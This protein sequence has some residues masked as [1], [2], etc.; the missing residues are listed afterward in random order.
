[1]SGTVSIFCFPQPTCMQFNF[2]L[3]LFFFKP[4]LRCSVCIWGLALFQKAVYNSICTE[5]E[6]SYMWEIMPFSGFPWSCASYCTCYCTC[7]CLLDSQKYFL[8]FQSPAWTFYLP[9]FLFCLFAW[10]LFSLATAVQHA[11]S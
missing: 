5:Y 3:L 11:G 8:L 4:L 6:V 9:G 2:L 1:M 10:F 7:M